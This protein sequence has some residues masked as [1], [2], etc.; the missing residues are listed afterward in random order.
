MEVVPKSELQMRM[1]DNMKILQPFVEI[2]FQPYEV[3]NANIKYIV[4]NVD[5]LAFVST[6]LAAGKAEKAI[7]TGMS[8]LTKVMSTIGLVTY[9][10]Y[11]VTNSNEFELHFKAQLQYILQNLLANKHDKFL[12]IVTFPVH[13][14]FGEVLEVAY[15]CGLKPGVSEEGILYVSLS[16]R[17]YEH[18][19]L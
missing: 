7:A 6:T 4:D 11:K 14:R 15:R 17:V 1:E 8:F 19:K 2:K 18:I 12:I 10:C 9:C 5:P 16:T 13:L 3:T